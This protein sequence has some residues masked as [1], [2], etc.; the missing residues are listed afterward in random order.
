[1]HCWSSDHF[2]V[3]SFSSV[4]SQKATKITKKEFQGLETGHCARARAMGKIQQ[5]S[6][7]EAA[8]GIGG[9]GDADRQDFAGRN[10]GLEERF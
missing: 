4:F 10:A 8:R 7:E 2:I 5:R 3:P 1:M 6:G 9:S